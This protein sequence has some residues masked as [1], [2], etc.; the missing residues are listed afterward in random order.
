MLFRSDINS[1]KSSKKSGSKKSNKS[2]V[3]E[4]NNN[5]INNNKNE[6]KKSQISKKSKTSKASKIEEA[7]KAEEEK[8]QEDIKS[9]N[10]KNS[11]KSKAEE[12]GFINK[13]ITKYDHIY[14]VGCGSAYHAGMIGKFLIEEYDFIKDEKSTSNFISRR[15]VANVDYINSDVIPN[16]DN[17]SFH[18]HNL[19]ILPALSICSKSNRRR[20]ERPLIGSIGIPRQIKE[21][22]IMDV[23]ILCSIFRDSFMREKVIIYM[24]IT[25]LQNIRNPT[26][27]FCYWRSHTFLGD[28]FIGRILNGFSVV[29]WA[30]PGLILLTLCF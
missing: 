19:S 5:N 18:W 16:E 4:T 26:A 24:M 2:K 20:E 7:K 21:R 11:K 25:R 30:F 6:E 27:F 1:K 29:G 22:I 28:S 9:K 14:I 3:N 13:D 12:L 17:T 10:S 8:K 23:L 15:S